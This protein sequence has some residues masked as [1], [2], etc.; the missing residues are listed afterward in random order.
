MKN[1]ELRQLALLCELMDTQSLNEAAA[2]LHMSASAASQSLTRLRHALGDEVCI[3]DHHRYQLTPF[4]E[5]ALASFRHMVDLWR[6]A[7]SDKG[8]FDPAQCETR[9]ALTCHD[10]WGTTGL[11]DLYRRCLAQAPGIALDIHAPANSPRDIEDLRAGTVDVA[12]S[13]QAAPADA[14]D[15]HMETVAHLRI[16]VCCL[17]VDHP[18]IGH[19]LSLDA[20]AAE[21]HLGIACHRRT[22][23]PR[24]PIDD[25]L[26]A[27]GR[28][29]RRHSAVQSWALCADL[30]ACTDRL[31]STS[32]GQAAVLMRAS[33]RIRCLPLPAG[34]PQPEVPLHLLW[35]QRTH[36]SKPHRWLR[37]RLREYLTDT[38]AP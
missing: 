33:P 16:A 38:A 30:V 10:G 34:L 32:A 36:Q 11:A 14:R 28:P 1:A 29:E 15:L 3:R 23:Q 18:R 20:Y 24:N 6:E 37:Q 35:H 27:M 22:G 25:A 8:L 19:M 2:R 17:R 13:Q 12:C 5:S 21:A 9:L 4:G 7:S 26:R 31:L